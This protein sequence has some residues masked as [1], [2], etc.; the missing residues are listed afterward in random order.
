M[1]T[2]ASWLG[3]RFSPLIDERH[4]E[5]ADTSDNAGSKV[6]VVD[7]EVRMRSSVGDLLQAYGHQCELAAG[8]EE[9]LGLLSTG[10]IDL[11]LLDLNMPGIDGYQVMREV[12][13]NYPDTDVIVVSGETTF[14]SATEALR[15]GAQD[16]LRKPYAPEELIRIVGNTLR[17]RSLERNIRDM[18]RCLEAS[19][20]RYRFIVNNSPDIIYMLDNRGHFVFLNDR[21]KTILG[22]ETDELLGK[23]YSDFVHKD[24]LDK[25]MYV[26]DE[27]RTGARASHNIE[28]RLLC[29]GS[30]LPFRYFE[31]RSI[32][33]ELSAMGVYAEQEAD[34]KEA[35]VGTYGVVRD[36]SER[37]RA[38]EVINFQLYHD[39]LTK[40]PNRALFRDRLNLAISQAKRSKSKLA[41]MFL[42]MDRFKVINDSLGHL[43]GDQLLQTIALRLSS[44][45]RDGDTLA[46]VGG[47][48]FN[49]L[50]PG[51]NG[52]DDAAMVARK[53]ME[54]LKEP[55]VLDGYEVF[56]SF[57]IGIAIFPEDGQTIDVLVKNSDMAMYH[58]KTHG[59]NGYE[60][61][62]DNM[63]AAFHRQLSMENGIRKALEKKEFELFYQPQIDV[64]EGR[65]CGMEALIRWNHPE[66]G[67][68]LPDQFIPL[69]EE[70]GLIVEIG[71]WVLDSACRE[72]KA[73]RLQGVS[74]DVQMAVNISAAQLMQP[75]FERTVLDI[76]AKHGVS[77]R[78]LELEITEN[79]LMQDMDQAVSKFQ[80]LAANGV[81]VAVDDFGIGYS[82][83]SYLH[84]LPLNTLKID[85]SFISGVQAAKDRSSIVTAVLAM[86]RELNL[87]VVVEG[88]E[89]KAQVDYLRRLECSKA[90]GFFL[91]RP[92]PSEEIRELLRKR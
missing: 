32:T 81:R 21:I 29:K 49:L 72:L 31:S 88:V 23:H 84:S 17:K 34:Q 75:E 13:E 64:M 22:Y 28:F 12:K 55:V 89:R 4:G 41:V 40:L 51:I 44:C 9:A 87:E 30:S 2:S 82:S 15:C 86:A 57:S 35:F 1:T 56:V 37:K 18:N 26:F 48:E 70:T 66:R 10:S 52:R 5:V 71:N 74:D 79:I 91:G 54:R 69:S 90:Q 58:T 46:R 77:G 43:A 7:D 24:D 80:Q 76:M 39:L 53:I 36:I 61:F 78:Q 92:G 33:I 14:E 73:W 68:L 60:F 50:V 83:L 38:E 67:V 45:L 6:L 85:R 27:R 62:A 3:A 20:H 42:D 11:M 25:A 65:V 8:G 47:D 16:F 59:K 19:E 63:K